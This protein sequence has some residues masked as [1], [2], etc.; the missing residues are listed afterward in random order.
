MH[1]TGDWKIVEGFDAMQYELNL[2]ALDDPI[3]PR[4]VKSVLFEIIVA[5]DYNISVVGF[6]GAN[7]AT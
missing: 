2:E 6:S 4:Q 3:N 1:E 7:A 5:G